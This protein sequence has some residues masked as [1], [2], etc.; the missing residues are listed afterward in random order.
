MDRRQL[1]ARIPMFLV[2]V[3]MLGC[4]GEEDDHYPSRPGGGG[5]Y[6]GGGAN[7]PE[8]NDD[9]F[10]VANEDDSDH[11]H[12]FQMSCKRLDEGQTVYTA[13]GPHT[14]TVTLTEADLEAVL[15]GDAVTI[16]TNGGHRHLW[17]VQM[18]AQLC[19]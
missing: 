16:E 12:S 6:G 10:L 18:P 19:T 5:G 7:P 17:V 13:L 14:H 11:A 4:L 8:G 1:L 9:S 15:R 2:A 3:P